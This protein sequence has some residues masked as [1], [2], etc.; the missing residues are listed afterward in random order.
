MAGLTISFS[1]VGSIALLFGFGIVIWRLTMLLGWKRRRAT[2]VS[3]SRQRAYRGSSFVKL[4]VRWV[5]ADG[6]SVEATDRGP[7]NRYA[8]GEEVTV[9]EMRGSE[10]PRIVVPEFL[11]FWLMALIFLPFGTAFLY[12]ALV[13]VPS[14]K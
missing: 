13:Y 9:L 8:E 3:Y 1:I 7:W 12:V 2:V 4:T 11:R 14:L 10:P 5:G 6:E